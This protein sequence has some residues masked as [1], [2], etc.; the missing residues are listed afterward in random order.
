MCPP[1]R[2]AQHLIELGADAAEADRFGLPPLYRALQHD[3]APALVGLLL[4]N[5]ASATGK[6]ELRR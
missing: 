5:G 3:S 4:D 1:L 2:A 6:G